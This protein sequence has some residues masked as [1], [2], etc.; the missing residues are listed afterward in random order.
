MNPITPTPAK[1]LNIRTTVNTVVSEF[2]IVLELAKQHPRYNNAES[3]FKQWHDVATRIHS[4]L[5]L[6]IRFF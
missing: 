5:N 6:L 4:L 2:G 3:T 1:K